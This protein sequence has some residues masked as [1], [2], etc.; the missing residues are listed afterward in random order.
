MSFRVLLPWLLATTLLLS[1]SDQP[2]RDGPGIRRRVPRTAYVIAVGIDN[3]AGTQLAAA[4]SDARKFAARIAREHCDTSCLRDTLPPALKGQLPRTSNP[5]LD[6]VV[7]SLVLDSA[8]T[9]AGIDRAFGDVVK[10]ARKGDV[11]IFFFAGMSVYDRDGAGG[12]TVS[13]CTIDALCNRARTGVGERRPMGRGGISGSRLRRWLESTSAERQLVVLDACSHRDYANELVSS[14]APN[15]ST[16]AGLTTRNRVVLWSLT[17]A[18][19]TADGGFLTD[20][21]TGTN[22]LLT[23]A[24]FAEPGRV[25]HRFEVDLRVREAE[26]SQRHQWADI[27]LGIFFERD[28]L[29]LLAGAMAD[30]SGASRGAGVVPVNGRQTPRPAHR[31]R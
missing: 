26:I 25:R 15:D 29:R 7:V 27:Q 3:Y 11:V 28:Y 1:A 13:L 31:T 8:A 20:I 14:V 22:D 17:T 24:P 2:P 23:D 5:D 4:A 18:G 16:V 6:S 9:L 30:D 10:R 19:E 21:I 12:K